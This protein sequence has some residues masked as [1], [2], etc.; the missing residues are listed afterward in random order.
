LNKF[1][2]GSNHETNN[3]LAIAIVLDLVTLCDIV[4]IG[5]SNVSRDNAHVRLLS[6]STVIVVRSHTIWIM[7]SIKQGKLA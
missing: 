1:I 6:H 3:K 4:T 2:H 5:N 7:S